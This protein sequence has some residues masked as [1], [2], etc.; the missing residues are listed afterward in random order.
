MRIRKRIV[1]GQEYYYLEESVRLGKTRIYSVFLGRRIPGKSQLEGKKEELLDKIYSDLLKDAEREYLTKEQLI[2]SEKKKRQY[3]Q[4]M[5][6]LGKAGLDEKEEVDT[7][8]FVYTTLSTEGVPITKED[9]DLAYKFSGNNVRNIRDENLR[10]ALDMING[11]RMVKE[12]KKGLTC[13][14]ILGLHGTIMHEYAEKNPGEFRKKQAR[15]YMKNYERMEEIGFRPAAPAEIGRKVDELVEWYNAKVGKLNAI[16]LA[17]LLHLRFYMI[18]PFGDGNKRVSRLLLNK[19][20]SDSGYPMLNVS[21][22]TA[23]YFDA[24]VGA[25]EKKDE[26]KFVEF[27]WAQFNKMAGDRR[28]KRRD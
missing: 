23:G 5:K 16:E 2:E 9:A 10:V 12:S 18:H 7:V 25:V 24:L 1:T 15:I 27:V 14:F 28:R 11:L 20:L 17:A 22:E 21:K 3:E 13:A 19:A 6:R 26:R 8:D 4:R